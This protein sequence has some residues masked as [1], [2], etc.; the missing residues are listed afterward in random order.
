VDALWDLAI[1]D[2][3]IFNHWLGELPE[4]VA[5][6]GQVWLQSD[7]TI[8]PHF[9]LGLAD[10]VWLRLFYPSGFQANIHVCWANPDKQRRIGIVGDRGTLL[11]DEMTPQTPLVVQQGTFQPQGDYFVPIGL[12]QEKLSVIPAEPLKQVCEHFIQ[13]IQT[14]QPSS[15]SSG[16]T[17]THLVEILSALSQSLN[18]GG[19]PVQ[20]RIH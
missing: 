12:E 14:Q 18:Q 17:A 6:H 8:P 3:A 2:I 4:A 13:C 9:P 16:E 5:A 7:R 20:V 15:I 11:F 10:V 19:Q 1:H